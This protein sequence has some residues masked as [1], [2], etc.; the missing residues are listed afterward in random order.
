MSDAWSRYWAREASG[1]CLP[2]A[3]PAV[4]LALEQLWTVAAQA[5]PVA[6][7]WLD[8]AAGGGAVAKVVRGV[9]NDVAVTG[10]DAAQVSPAAAALGVRGGID[11]AGLP[12][13]DASFAVVSSQFGL[14]YCPQAAWAEAARVLAPGGALLLV[15]H[16]AASRAVAH[17]RARL[18]AMRA[19][20]AAGLFALAEG[21]AAGRG[22]DAGLVRQVM[23]ARAA[24]PGHSV[25]AELPQ[26][27]GQWA[28]AGR[29]DAVAAIRAEAEAEMT[30]L[31]AMQGA[32]LDADG[33]GERQ[34][35]LRGRASR[36]E[37]LTEADGT[38]ICWVLRI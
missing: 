11:A 9:R 29:P 23:A 10:I 6:A 2:G 16:H 26:A 22:E 8:V 14:E 18:A 27:L 24:H 33:I 31:A 1:A 13:G 19:L 20:V 36:V 25:V 7:A 38:P 35:W 21:L 5:A 3:P 30:R 34:D 4:Q 12:F 28:R 17:N 37:C 15:C 32:A